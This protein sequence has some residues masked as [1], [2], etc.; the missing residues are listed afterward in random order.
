MS[1]RINTVVTHLRPEDA[2]TIIE[3]LDQL[4]YVL[5]Q[6]YGNDIRA[7]LQEATTTF[8]RES[9]QEGDELF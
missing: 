5:L 2:H 8:E 4:R 1:M 7:M 3:F 9:A 6:N